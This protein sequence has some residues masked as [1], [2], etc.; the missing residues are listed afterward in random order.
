MSLCMCIAHVHAELMIVR[1][2]LMKAICRNRINIALI[3]AKALAK[4]N[5]RK[6]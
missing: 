2:A 4:N 5:I 1:L 6:H 3:E